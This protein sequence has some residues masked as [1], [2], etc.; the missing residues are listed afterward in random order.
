MLKT[1]AWLFG[2]CMWRKASPDHPIETTCQSGDFYHLCEN[3]NFVTER[4]KYNT[5]HSSV[6]VCCEFDASR[7]VICQSL[8]HSLNWLFIQVDARVRY[9]NCQNKSNRNSM[10]SSLNVTRGSSINSGTDTLL[11]HYKIH[12]TERERFAMLNC[13]RPAINTPTKE[14]G[15]KLTTAANNGFLSSSW[16]LLFGSFTTMYI[17]TATNTETRT[18]NWYGDY[19][20]DKSIRRLFCTFT[21]P[22]FR[23]CPSAQTNFRLVPSTRRRIRWWQWLCHT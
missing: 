19:L 6:S 1:A 23:V 21:K 22:H 13:I 16:P 11:L 2:W 20:T 10:V 15:G 7:S 3:A 12:H 18:E 4:T 17:N 5:I 14:F 8:N 9:A